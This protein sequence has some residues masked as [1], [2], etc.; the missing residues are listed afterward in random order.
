[1]SMFCFPTSRVES[2]LVGG[3]IVWITSL[4]IP[5]DRDCYWKG[6]TYCEEESWKIVREEAISQ[7]ATTSWG[8]LC[9]S[10][11]VLVFKEEDWLLFPLVI[12]LS[13]SSSNL[14]VWVDISVN[15]D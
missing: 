10:V 11:G 1:M 2:K 13:C 7:W 5:G 3:S 12:S 6:D 8:S 15:K 14:V 9:Y 4:L